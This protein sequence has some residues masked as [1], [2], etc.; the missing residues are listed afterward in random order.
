[1][2]IKQLFYIFINVAQE[3]AERIREMAEEIKATPSD[4]FVDLRVDVDRRIEEINQSLNDSQEEDTFMDKLKAA[5]VYF[6]EGNVYEGHEIADKIIEM[7]DEIR[8][9]T[10]DIPDKDT[11][12]F[13]DDSNKLD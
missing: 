13:T 7:M 5:L 9:Q 10:L 3:S 2:A 8:S 11:Y 6:T 12:K 1:M 4:Q